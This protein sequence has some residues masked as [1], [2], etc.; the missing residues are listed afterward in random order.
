MAF[1]HAT[2][3]RQ[4][5]LDIRDV[6]PLS[7]LMISVEDW[8]RVDSPMSDWRKVPG[9]DWSYEVRLFLN[10]DMFMIEILLIAFI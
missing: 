8:I 1:E 5:L 7:L 6:I 10:K 2:T 4:L 9:L 3:C